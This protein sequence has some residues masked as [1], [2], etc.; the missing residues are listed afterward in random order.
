MIT[1]ESIS[2]RVLACDNA[3]ENPIACGSVERYGTSEWRVDG[4]ELKIDASW[5]G[6]VSLF[7]NGAGE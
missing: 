1:S 7:G 3:N 6:H 4:R 2:Y 5:E